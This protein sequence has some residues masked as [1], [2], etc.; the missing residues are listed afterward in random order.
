MIRILITVFV[1]C[2]CIL[3]ADAQE[4][5]AA[6]RPNI[7]LIM[8]D[9]MGFSDLGC[10]G[11]EIATPNIDRLAE[12]G[13]R[14][15]QF[16]NNARCCPSRAALLTGLYSHQAGVGHG[17]VDRGFPGY[18][19]RLNDR[20]VTIG[21]VLRSAGYRT[22]LSG[23]WHVGDRR[24][25]WPVDRGFD[26]S[27]V[28]IDG[29]TNY[30][31]LECD[32]RLALD[33]KLIQPEQDWYITDAI[34]QRAVAFL[35]EHGKSDKPFFLYVPYTAP[36]WP[37]HALPEDIAKYKGKYLHGWDALRK[38]RH[39]RLIEM[40]LVDAK[41]PLT[42]R[43]AKVPAWDH[44]QDKEA[45]DHKMAVYAAQ[46]DR[47]DQG[48]GKILTQVRS[49]GAEHNTLVMFLSDNGSCNEVLDRGKP[50]AP[51]GT[52]DSFLSYGVGWANAS[53]TPFRLY[54]SW[55]HE[56]GIAT[57]FVAYW[58]AVIKKPGISHQQGHIIDFMATCVDIAGVEYPKEFQGRKI[59]PL[60]GKSLLPV[61]QGKT[62]P[63]HEA[64]YWEHQGNRAVRQG[65][66]KLVARFK[67]PWELYDLD[68]DRTEMQD[69]AHKHPEKVKEL[70]AMYERWARRTG[71][72]PFEKVRPR[73]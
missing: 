21:E 53:N 33:D 20:C 37:L 43:D 45:W 64:L 32:Q 48:I 59:T 9:D 10:Y 28:L 57:P 61:F 42:P 70:A 65:K 50:G 72:V 6:L 24:P 63:E 67:A 49:L 47:M 1:M 73:R 27:Y 36:H 25:H 18:L 41:W 4:K 62:R 16:Y 56:G 38:Q 15:T 71:V 55:A 68:A 54:K 34:S 69:L 44:V 35:K 40:G 8:A 2:C 19:G 12:K 30:F 46:I 51:V 5:Q 14:F 39:K 52:A 7:I 60:E 17:A 66:W 31:R 13:L 29:F 23:K 11:S 26:R 3:P 22:Y 58:P